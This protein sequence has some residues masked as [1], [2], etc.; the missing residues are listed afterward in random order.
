MILHNIFIV[1]GDL[2]LVRGK[3]EYYH[4]CQ[5]GEDDNGWGCAYRSLQTLASWF[6]LQGYVEKPVPTIADIQKCLVDIKDKPA[7]FVGNLSNQI[8]FLWILKD[9]FV[10][11]SRQW[12]GSTEVS[13]VLNTLFG[14]DSKILHVS[15][16]EEMGT[17]GPELVN[18]F[19][20]Q[21]SPIMIGKHNS[22]QLHIDLGI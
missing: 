18:H 15:S 16:G 17:K 20:T 6:K 11:G 9:C 5:N 4:Y 21:G 8:F 7:N 1:G 12:I 19:L 22:L 3:Y 13:F 2:A 14:I 10:L